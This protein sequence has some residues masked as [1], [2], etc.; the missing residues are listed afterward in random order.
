MQKRR[1]ANIPTAPA[2]I[3]ETIKNLKANIY[4]P[5]YQGMFLDSVSAHLS[6]GN[7]VLV[8][9]YECLII[10]QH[11]IFVMVQSI[12]VGSIIVLSH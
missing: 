7:D 12:K 10:L 8:I 1:R 11:L 2:S 3:E 4:S 5:F 9:A 6:G